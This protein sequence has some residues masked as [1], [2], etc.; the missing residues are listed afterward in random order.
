M[1]QS[2]MFYPQKYRKKDTPAFRQIRKIKRYCENDCGRLTVGIVNSKCL[3]S[4]C[5]DD[6]RMKSR[7]KWKRKPR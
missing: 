4:K 6:E 7:N 5:C 2:M 1:G 3:C